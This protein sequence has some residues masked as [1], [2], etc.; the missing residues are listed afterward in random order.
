MSE[1]A[2]MPIGDLPEELP[3]LHAEIAK[4]VVGQETAKNELLA[5]CLTGGHVLIEGV[6]AITPIDKV[7]ARCRELT[8]MRVQFTPDLMPTGPLSR[9]VRRVHR[10]FESSSRGECGP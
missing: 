10:G 2:P 4:A 5:A 7:L 6:P 8:F 1:L 9:T 3:V